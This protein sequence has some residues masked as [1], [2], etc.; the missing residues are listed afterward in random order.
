[1]SKEVGA[2][3]RFEIFLDSAN[4]EKK[5]NEEFVKTSISLTLIN[6]GFY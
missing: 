4:N 1:M 3:G 5:R 6:G 2:V